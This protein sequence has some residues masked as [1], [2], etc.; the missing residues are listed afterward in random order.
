MRRVVI[1]SPFAGD[2]AANLDYAR[3]ALL[4]CLRRGEA[5]L[6]SHLLYTQVLDDAEPD[7]R[8]LGVDAGLAWHRTAEAVVVYGDCGISPG[9]RV[10]IANARRLDI[11]VEYRY[12][13]RPRDEPGVETP[14]IGA[15]LPT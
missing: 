13:D 8:R 1:E 2:A 5:P 10:G 11:P 4:D 12:L 9:M 14:F 15:E 6:A 7:Q 3:R